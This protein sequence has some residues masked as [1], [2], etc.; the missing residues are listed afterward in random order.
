M[1]KTKKEQQEAINLYTNAPGKL[2]LHQFRT[3]LNFTINKGLAG[4]E[5]DDLANEMYG[6]LDFDVYLESKGMNLQRPLVWSIEQKRELILSILKEIKIPAI[7]MVQYIND[8]SEREK[9]IYKII[10][11]KQ[12]L[13]A[14]ISF[15]R[16]EFGIMFEGQEYFYNDL[17]EQAK[18]EIH[19]AFRFDVG[20][21]YPDKP[22]TDKE[23]ILWFQLINFTGTPQDAEHMKNLNKA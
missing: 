4:F 7:T 23:M 19:H 10:D 16:G 6:K 5:V 20:Y 2:A 13:S 8:Y 17:T 11:G 18:S 15:Y 22:I 12:R 9:R 14:A 1:E 21:S 3:P